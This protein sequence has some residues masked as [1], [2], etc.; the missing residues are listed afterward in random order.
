MSNV[1]ID[2]VLP[3]QG[4]IGK[5]L[6][7]IR[8]IYVSDAIRCLLVVDAR[9]CQQRWDSAIAL[10]AFNRL[11]IAVTERS[12]GDVATALY[13]FLTFIEAR[14]WQALWF[15]IPA[16]LIPLWRTQDFQTLQLDSQR[17]AYCY[18]V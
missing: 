12:F 16:T 17:R 14:G 2:Q 9:C 13:E 7:S 3:P 4:A 1:A 5:S 8:Q 18:R 10:E 15:E 11:A 6:Y